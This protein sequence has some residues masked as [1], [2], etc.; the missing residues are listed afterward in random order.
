MSQG[1]IRK[2][3]NND[4]KAEEEMVNTIPL[5]G[6]GGGMWLGIVTG[7]SCTLHVS[8]IWV[9]ATQI[10]V[11][12]ERPKEKHTRYRRNV[13]LWV[14]WCHHHIP[15]S[16]HTVYPRVVQ[17][18]SNSSHELKKQMKQTKLSP[19]SF[20]DHVYHGFYSCCSDTWVLVTEVIPYNLL[21]ISDS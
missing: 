2:I 15:Q 21:D 8:E 13:C 12:A 19:F 20:H 1:D 7:V 16:V 5:Q 18:A 17:K 4:K 11:K 3:F 6:P 14:L 10:W 9:I